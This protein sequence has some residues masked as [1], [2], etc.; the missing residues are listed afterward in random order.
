MHDLTIKSKHKRA[1]IVFMTSNDLQNND[2]KFYVGSF[3]EFSP[4]FFW[5]D[6]NKES[7]GEPTFFSS[8]AKIKTI[9]SIF[10]VKKTFFWQNFVQ[11]VT[12][13]I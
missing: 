9:Y 8:D 13:T 4:Y 12:S 7:T 1:K 11:N 2:L 3:L 5:K 6:N 10:F